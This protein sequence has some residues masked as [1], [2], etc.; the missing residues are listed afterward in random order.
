MRVEGTSRSRKTLALRRKVPMWDEDVLSPMYAEMER[1]L[2]VL[3]RMP[4]RLQ[5]LHPQQWCHP[6]PRYTHHPG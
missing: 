1:L 6:P 2:I 5:V 3:F 4:S